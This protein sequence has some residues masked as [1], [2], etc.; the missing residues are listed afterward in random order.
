[1]LP[2]ENLL[3]LEEYDKSS[4]SL[5][6]FKIK[7]IPKFISQIINNKK[8]NCKKVNNNLCWMNLVDFSTLP[9]QKK[10][11]SYF[12]QSNKALQSRQ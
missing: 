9:K 2:Y 3:S 4:S 12:Y 11:Y 7:I 8:Q 10:D 5:F 1:M 6:N